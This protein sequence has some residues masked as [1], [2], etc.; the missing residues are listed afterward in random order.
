[1]AFDSRAREKELLLRLDPL[2][3][4]AETKASAPPAQLKQDRIVLTQ[5]CKDYVTTRNFHLDLML[6]QLETAVIDIE[7]PFKTQLTELTPFIGRTFAERIKNNGKPSPQAELFCM[8]VEIEEAAFLA[9]MKRVVVAATKRDYLMRYEKILRKHTEDLEVRWKSV[10]AQHAGYDETERRI[11]EEIGRTIAEAATEAAAQT[12]PRSES[13]A[14][15]LDIALGLPIPL[16]DTLSTIRTFAKSAVGYWR[17]VNDL[18]SYRQSLF[19]DAYKSEVSTTL[20]LFKDFRS[21]TR[22]FIDEYNYEKAEKECESG[23][24]AL[25]EL[26][27]A[28][29]SPAQKEDLRLFVNEAR[30]RLRERYNKGKW[31]WDDFVRKHDRKF[32][33]A[34]VPHI[35]DELLS[36]TAWNERKRNMY[37]MN[38]HAMLKVWRDDNRHLKLVEI[39]NQG[40]EVKQL[41]GYIVEEMVALKSA[42]DSTMAAVFEL[43]RLNEAREQDARSLDSA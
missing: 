41:V 26:V 10:I 22:R 5:A 36:T 16:P 12:S 27:N 23:E 11:A 32:F 21:E 19:K 30:L 15:Y 39:A 13:Y 24:A 29:P 33:G 20:V 25:E 35:K 8:R 42:L 3:A 2:F 38:L 18:F 7:I 17:K 34:V 6:R 4:E 28:C 14:R 31:A 9:G 43:E 1:M 37:H 40:A